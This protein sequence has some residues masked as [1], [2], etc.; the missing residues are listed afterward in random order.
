MAGLQEERR[1]EKGTLGKM[2]VE[3]SVPQQL[4]DWEGTH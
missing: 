2:G 4:G 3:G 1:E